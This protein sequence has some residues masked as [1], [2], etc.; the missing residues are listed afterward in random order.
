M[1]DSDAAGYSIRA[2]ERVCAIL[3]LIQRDPV[4]LTASGVAQAAEI[5][6][7]SAFRYLATLETRSYV[8][9]DADDGT[10]RIGPAFL[11]SSPR[12][13]SVLVER[14]RPVM[15]GLRD[16]YGE[17]INLAVLEG[18][19]AV[20]VEIVE[21]LR[22]MRLAVRKGDRDPLHCTAVG[23][24]IAAQLPES[25]VISILGAEGMPVRT[26]RSISD[27]PTYLKEIATTRRRG[28]GLDDR[29]YE[30]DGRCVAVSIGGVRVP[31]ALSLS[32]PSARFP[33]ADVPEVAE[34]LSAAVRQFVST[35]GKE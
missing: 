22:A 33:L 23:K 13:L 5:P 21:S 14:A 6:K 1:T 24:V 25:D 27:L 31:A 34:N 4:G 10:Y 29:E 28:Y 16:R 8:A 20:Y 18:T 32:A 30:A 2:V 3:D 12:A 35:G 11:P 26:R 7:S 9:R 17:T 19:R 15:V